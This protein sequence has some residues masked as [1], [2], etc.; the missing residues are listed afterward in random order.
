[1]DKDTVIAL[2]ILMGLVALVVKFPDL[3]CWLFI[4]FLFYLFVKRI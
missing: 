3:I 1:M 4:G 2:V